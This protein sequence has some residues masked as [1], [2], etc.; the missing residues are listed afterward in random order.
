MR[1]V[2]WKK[3]SRDHRDRRYRMY[4]SYLLQKNM[5]L[6]FRYKEK[7]HLFFTRWWI[8]SLEKPNKE[9]NKKKWQRH[10]LIKLE[11]LPSVT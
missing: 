9:Q 1:V 6:L 3:K 5:K 2:T 7:I 10:P 11:W 8:K 4:N